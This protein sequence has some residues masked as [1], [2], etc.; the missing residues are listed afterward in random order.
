M[1]KIFQAGRMWSAAEIASAIAAQCP[2][3]LDAMRQLVEIERLCSRGSQYSGHDF[4][5][6]SAALDYLGS[7]GRVTA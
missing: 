6:L 7:A 1:Y 2:D 3:S 4:D 5:V